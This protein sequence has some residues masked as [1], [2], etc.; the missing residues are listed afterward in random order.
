MKPNL[1]DW[2]RFVVGICM[3]I[4]LI[5]IVGVVLYSLVFVTQPMV[6]QAPNDAEFFKLGSMATIYF[7][8]TSLIWPA[9]LAAAAYQARKDK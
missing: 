8:A 5:G 2:L 1:D 6:G 4:T 3:A 7:P 9:F